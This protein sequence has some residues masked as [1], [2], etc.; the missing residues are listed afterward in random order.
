MPI[1]RH[2]N[3]CNESGEIYCCLRNR[4]VQLDDEQLQRFCQGCG[5]F[6]GTMPDVGISCDWDDFGDV[7]DPHHALDPWIEYK[8]NQMR[9]VSGEGGGSLQRCS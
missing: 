7:A 6:A 4:V 5:M 1:I 2:H 8:R 9:Q 3:Y